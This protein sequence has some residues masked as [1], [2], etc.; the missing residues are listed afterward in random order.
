MVG[1]G[2]MWKKDTSVPFVYCLEL[3]FTGM[4]RRIGTMFDMGS[5]RKFKFRRANLLML[6]VRF[7]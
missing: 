5:V 6:F 1:S 7:V 4:L 2:R 3:S